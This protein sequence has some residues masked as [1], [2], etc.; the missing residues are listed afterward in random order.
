MG[1]IVEK[2]NR[3]EMDYALLFFKITVCI[4]GRV[5]STT[6]HWNCAL[7]TNHN[8]LSKSADLQITH[9]NS[10]WESPRECTT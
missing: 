10:M 4:G 3:F 2:K 7:N 1:R 5:M 9:N 6:R 8:Q